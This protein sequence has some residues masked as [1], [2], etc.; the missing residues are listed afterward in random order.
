MNISPENVNINTIINNA[1]NGSLKYLF[2][3]HGAD[4]KVVKRIII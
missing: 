3:N 4:K 1:T 2:A